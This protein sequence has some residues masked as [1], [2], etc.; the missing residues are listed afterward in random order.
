MV[1]KDEKGV[2]RP[3]AVFSKKDALERCC[4]SRSSRSDCSD[5]RITKRVH[6]GRREGLKCT[7]EL[8]VSPNTFIEASAASVNVNAS[9]N[10]TG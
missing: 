10:T 9:A 3:L 5:A 4:D 2:G 7:Q 1:A 8:Q 6:N